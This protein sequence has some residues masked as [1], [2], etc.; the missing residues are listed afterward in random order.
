MS[1]WTSLLP[2]LDEKERHEAIHEFVEPIATLALL[3][4]YMLRSRFLYATAHLCHQVNLIREKDWGEDALPLESAIWF[5]AADKQGKPWKAYRAL[6]LRM[7]KM[8]GKALAAS[9]ADF[10][11]AF[12]H[13]FSARIGVGITNFTDRKVD[14]ETGSIF[15]T[16]GGTDPLEPSELVR[17]LSSE[18]EYSYD[19]F[20][21]FQALVAEHSEFI[22]PHN[23]DLLD[24]MKDKNLT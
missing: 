21:A 5:D 19:A 12:S 13:R 15:Y 20:S 3:S 1:T 7:E 17:L 22:I 23:Q 11:N 10:R 9:T 24:G 6:K 14:A 8:A 4:P 16:F 2:T 18:L